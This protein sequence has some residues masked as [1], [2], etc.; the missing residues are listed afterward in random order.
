MAKAEGIS[1]QI[2]VYLKATKEQ[3]WESLTVPKEAS[4]YFMCPMIRCGSRAGEI[5]EYGIGNEVMIGGEIIVY[6]ENDTL[7]YTFKFDPNTHKGTEEDITTIVK[8]TISEDRGITKMLLVHSGFEK[9]DQ[10]YVNITGGWP[11]IISNQKTYLE[12]GKTLTEK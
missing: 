6:Q 9:Q 4:K 7:T 1:Y 3:V 10:S 12:T 8:I 11:W 2:E 5:I